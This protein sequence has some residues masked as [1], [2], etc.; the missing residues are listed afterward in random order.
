MDITLSLGSIQVLCSIEVVYVWELGD[1]LQRVASLF[2]TTAEDLTA[3]NMMCDP[4]CLQPGDEICLSSQPQKHPSEAGSEPIK[5]L[6]SLRPRST[7]QRAPGFQHVSSWAVRRGINANW[8]YFFVG[9]KSRP[10]SASNAADL[11]LPFHQA[12]DTSDIR[13]LVPSCFLD[14]DTAG[15]PSRCSVGC[16]EWSIFDTLS[17]NRWICFLFLA[18]I[19]QIGKTQCRKEIQSSLLHNEGFEN[20]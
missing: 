2:G 12:R 1:D 15:C 18:S 8:C 16:A 5:A 17:S 11:L 20:A 6:R 19:N 10:N 4:S 7:A 14:G 13:Y 3:A 9:N